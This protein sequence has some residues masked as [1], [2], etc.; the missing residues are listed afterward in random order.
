MEIA[1]FWIPEQNKTVR[2]LLCPNKCLIK[3]NQRGLCKIRINNDGVLYSDGYGKIVSYA[4]DPIEKKPLYH[5]YPSCNILSIGVNGCNLSCKFCQNWQV[6]Q[7]KKTTQ[8]LSP[9]ELLTL[10]KN[11]NSFGI[12]YT[13][14]EPL[15][16]FEYLLDTC[17]ISHENDIKN[18]LVTNGYICKEPAEQLLPFIDAINIDLKSINPDF[19]KDVCGGQL[20][21]VLDF[22][23]LA[24]KSTH[25]EIT[26]LLIPSLND[27][28][29]EIHV[30]SKK[31]ADINPEI[32]VHFSAY[33]PQYKM[34]IPPTPVETMKRAYNIATQYLHYV[35]LG[36]V[37]CELGKN[38][39]CSECNNLLVKRVGYATHIVGLRNT[40]CKKCDFLV[41][42]IY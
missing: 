2:C 27:S 13:Y 6:S 19:Y 28:D 21:P 1:Q 25:I 35:Y 10:A 32:P 37:N 18:I 20:E 11:K 17:N 9:D 30:L 24:S 26:N 16:W 3:D 15:I 29:E 22:I 12:A 14:T 23:E 34:D 5:F 41:P 31:I 38:T 40:R 7:C 4:I 33:F 36:N 39:Y 42:I 8:Y